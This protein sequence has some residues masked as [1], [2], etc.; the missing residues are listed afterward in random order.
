MSA[1]R[2]A[3]KKPIHFT[4]IHIL[5]GS[6]YGMVCRLNMNLAHDGSKLCAGTIVQLHM[7]TPLAYV[8]SSGGEGHA[9]QCHAP[10][11]VIPTFS[12]GYWLPPPSIA[13]PMTCIE[14]SLQLRGLNVPIFRT[15]TSTEEHKEL[16]DV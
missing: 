3:G 12:N 4:H 2:Q 14:L 9:C 1:T 6:G 10:M 16:D 11:I 13:D 15:K 7:F 8:T 5:D